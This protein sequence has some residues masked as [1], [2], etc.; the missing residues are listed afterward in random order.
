MTKKCGTCKYG[1]FRMTNH[2]KPRP[3]PYSTGK[4]LF[5]LPELPLTPEWVEVKTGHNYISPERGERCNTY[6]EKL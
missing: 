3:I 5:V 1:E 2:A 6:E 4:C